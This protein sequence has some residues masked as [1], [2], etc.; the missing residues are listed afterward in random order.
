MRT[1]Q[2]KQTIVKPVLRRKDARRLQC[3]LPSGGSR[4]VSAEISVSHRSV[5]FTCSS[6]SVSAESLPIG[7][8]RPPLQRACAAARWVGSF[9]GHRR[10]ATTGIW[11]RR[12]RCPHTSRC[13]AARAA[14]VAAVCDYRL[15]P[16]QAL[17]ERLYS[18]ACGAARRIGF[19]FGGHRRA[20]T[21][22]DVADPPKERCKGGSSDACQT[23]SFSKKANRS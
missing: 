8:H 21:K 18:G 3:A 17:T 11:V 2:T 1:I 19:P 12:G 9:G 4:S 16:A 14:P 23:A 13:A 20:A 5:V 15:C 6:V 10:A 22:G 7:G